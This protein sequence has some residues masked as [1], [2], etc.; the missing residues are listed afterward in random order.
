MG[1]LV[2]SQ[3]RGVWTP[4]L[5][6]AT[7]GDLSVTYGANN[8]LGTYELDEGFVTLMFRI[9]TATFTHTTASGALRITGSPF[10]AAT[11]TSFAW[12]GTMIFGGITKANYTQIVP[13]IQSATNIID[14][15]G[16]GSGQAVSQ[17]AF[18]DCPTGGSMSIS[19]SLRFP[20]A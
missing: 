16:S 18:G 20:I 6:F 9:F 10:T 19:G 11:L 7:P 5:T 14:F 2:K 8:Q 15:L 3:L 4:A 12:Y 1:E 17:I 13:R